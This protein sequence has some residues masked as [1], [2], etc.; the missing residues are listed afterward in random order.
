[1]ATAAAVPTEMYWM[2]STRRKGLAGTLAGSPPGVGPNRAHT[3]PPT[4]NNGTDRIDQTAERTGTT[5]EAR[6]K[7]MQT[8]AATTKHACPCCTDRVDSPAD[9]ILKVNNAA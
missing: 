6:Y 4:A 9:R 3:Y 8:E 5:Q 2:G 7:A 1:M